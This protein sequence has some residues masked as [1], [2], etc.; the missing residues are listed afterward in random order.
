MSRRD[1]GR[2]PQAGLEGADL[3]QAQAS[4]ATLAGIIAGRRRAAA[5][6]LAPVGPRLATKARWDALLHPDQ[7]T[8]PSTWPDAPDSDQ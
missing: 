3:A 2:N 4:D 6:L 1:D 7:A 8:A 5:A